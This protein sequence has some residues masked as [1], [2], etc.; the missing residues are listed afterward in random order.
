LDVTDL[1]GKTTA[2]FEE[3]PIDDDSAAQTN[4]GA[5]VNEIIHISADPEVIFT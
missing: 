5:E 1:T 4:V 3:L 2:A